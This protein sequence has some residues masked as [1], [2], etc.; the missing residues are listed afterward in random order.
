M[1]DDAETTLDYEDR[2]PTSTRRLDVPEQSADHDALVMIG[3]LQAVLD[4]SSDCSVNSQ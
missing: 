4:Y 3:T 2:M 1:V